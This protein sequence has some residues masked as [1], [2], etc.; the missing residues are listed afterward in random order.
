MWPQRPAPLV[1]EHFQKGNL[2]DFCLFFIHKLFILSQ[3]KE[4][5][6]I[7]PRLLPVWPRPER[8][9][10]WTPEL[11]PRGERHAAADRR[12]HPRR[13]NHRRAQQTNP[14]RHDGQSEPL[15]P[16]G[17]V[18]SE[19]GRSTTCYMNPAATAVKIPKTLTRL[20]I[21][22]FIRLWAEMI[23]VST[24]AASLRIKQH[25]LMKNRCCWSLIPSFRS[26][27]HQHSR[28]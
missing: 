13:P 20:W 8:E 18:Q 12:L 1:V 15:T 6:Q 9:R 5:G 2:K 27:K 10:W 22:I 14:G 25:S 21:C 17:A 16:A 11:P 4:A 3:I 28:I 7:R 19:T 23:L 26:T 24:A